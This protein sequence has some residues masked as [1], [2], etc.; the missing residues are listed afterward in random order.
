MHHKNEQK[1]LEIDNNLILKG[2]NCKNSNC[3]KGYC[4]CH[5]KGRK[6]NEIC[7]C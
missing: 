4:V 5:S 2:C 7:K 6:C 1:A 3:V